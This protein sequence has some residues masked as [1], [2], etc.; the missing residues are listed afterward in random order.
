MSWGL[1]LRSFVFATGGSSGGCSDA[2]AGVEDSCGGCLWRE[3]R[4]RF[5]LRRPRPRRRRGL[6]NRF[7][8]IPGPDGGMQVQA[9]TLRTRAALDARQ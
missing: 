2:E 6:P 3:M 4:L 1:G 8:A 9:Q 5:A 7:S